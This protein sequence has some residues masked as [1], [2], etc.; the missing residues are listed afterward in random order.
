[1]TG[2]PSEVYSLALEER[3]SLVEG[4][5]RLSARIAYL[6]LV[7]ALVGAALVGSVLVPR[8]LS[9]PWLLAPVAVFAIA[10]RIHDRVLRRQS[11][12]ERGA[13]FYER[14]LARIHDR[15]AGGGSAG[16]EHLD[17]R[18]PYASDLDLFGRASLFELLSTARTRSGEKTLASWLLSPARPDEVRARQ[19]AVRELRSRL[20]LRE[21]LS[22]LGEDVRSGVDTDGL[23]AWA[24]APPVLEAGLQVGVGAA[25]ALVNVTT[26]ALFLAAVHGSGPFLLA[27]AASAVFVRV[28][29]R[30]ALQVLRAVERPAAELRILAETLKRLERESLRAPLLER[31]AAALR[32]AMTPASRRIAQLARLSEWNESRRNQIF[33]PVASLFLLGTQLAF[34]LERFRAASGGSVKRWVDAVGAMEA[35]GSLAAFAYEHPEDPFPEILERGPAFDARGLGHPLLP[36]GRSVRNDVTMGNGAH[37]L[38]VSG[39]NMS[40]KS[41]LLR[42]VGV[43]TVLALAG[44]PVR[45]SSLRLSPVQVG[46]CMRV[47]DSLAEGTSHFYAEIQRLRDLVDLGQR[48]ELPLL[49]LLD[50]ILHGTNS[51]DRR[52]GAEALVRGLLDRGAIGLVTTHDLALAG[53]AEDLAPRAINVHFE[54]HLEGDRIVFDY[55]LKPGVVKKGNALAL[56][57]AIGLDV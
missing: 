47:Q 17:P 1:V 19:E 49:F 52:V 20:D 3:L 16:E 31:L 21:D 55:R 12:A 8:V 44:A 43:N 30:R 48:G 45:A 51:H 50:E 54:D 22:V 57:R 29:R 26:L 13:R 15:W 42:S 14:G 5:R 23:I 56:M 6:R 28:Y 40:G 10:A 37:L 4:S 53:I 34:A 2:S 39:S 27:S 11:R 38:M 41:T 46:A 35:L 7:V 32:D 24:S 9:W 33:A 36:I 25:L 18:H